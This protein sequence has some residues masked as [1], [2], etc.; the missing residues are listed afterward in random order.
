MASSEF[1]LWTIAERLR[2]FLVPSAH[3]F[4]SG[5]A[6]IR[7]P[8]GRYASVDSESLAAFEVT[9]EQA[10]RWAKGE[11][12]DTLEQLK[13]GLDSKLKE[14][15]QQLY[16][17]A[18]SPAADSGAVTPDAGAALLDFLRSLPGVVGQSLSGEQR[19]VSAARGT[20]ARLEQRLND[21]GVGLQGNF[22]K[23]AERLAS[24]RQDLG[25]QS[26]ESQNGDGEPP[27]PK[28]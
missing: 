19:R 23:F 5:P 12:G 28:P 6:I 26:A 8:A 1:E 20:A 14:V 17:A 25:D 27:A 13:L 9:E 4:K 11:F 24:L 16:A 18:A 3:T 22:S 15:S 7:T 10:R 21:A 2:Y